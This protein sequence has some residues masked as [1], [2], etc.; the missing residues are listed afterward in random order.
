METTIYTWASI[1]SV[2]NHNLYGRNGF[3]AK[4]DQFLKNFIKMYVAAFVGSG[5]CANFGAHVGFCATDGTRCHRSMDIKLRCQR[6]NITMLGSSS[7]MKP[8]LDAG[9]MAV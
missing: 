3:P 1:P 7:V 8:I 9:T 2:E 5:S 4:G 6:A